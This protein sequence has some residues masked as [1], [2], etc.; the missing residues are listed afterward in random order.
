MI[1]TG[2]KGP[3]NRPAST[4][5]CGRAPAER[6]SEPGGPGERCSRSPAHYL[7]MFNEKNTGS[8]NLV[9]LLSVLSGKRF[10]HISKSEFEPVNA[11]TL[12]SLAVWPG[13]SSGETEQQVCRRTYVS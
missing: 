6:G 11:S 5:P 8:Y 3:K 13:R 2:V 10:R 4:P 1:S 7:S 12:C 9:Y